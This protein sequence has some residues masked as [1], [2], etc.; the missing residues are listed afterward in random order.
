MSRVGCLCLAL[1]GCQLVFDLSPGPDVGD[2]GGGDAAGFE[3]CG[4]QTYDRLRYF[5]VPN[6]GLNWLAA[7]TACEHRG[8]DL[9]VFD[10]QAELEEVRIEGQAPYWLGVMAMTSVDDCP[11]VFDFAA[12]QPED[13]AGCLMV[14][15][16]SLEM[17]QVSCD[18]TI[19]P[20]GALIGGLCET[21]RASLA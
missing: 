15:D 4:V 8:M 11:P 1:A 20:N 12:T 13:P 6:D 18:N 21:P 19:A 16:G 10:T 7:K 2:G 3:A 9:A 5:S 14:A 17:A